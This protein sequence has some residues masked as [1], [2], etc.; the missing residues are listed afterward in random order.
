M[1]A[2]LNP[3]IDTLSYIMSYLLVLR[4]LLLPMVVIRGFRPA[5]DSAAARSVKVIGMDRELLFHFLHSLDLPVGLQLLLSCILTLQLPLINFLLWL[6]YV[7][8]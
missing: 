1:W 7:C 2:E 4:L 5:Y 6:C 3:Q 8:T